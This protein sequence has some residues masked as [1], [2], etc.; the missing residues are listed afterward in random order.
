MKNF[1]TYTFSVLLTLAILNSACGP[2]NNSGCNNLNVIQNT[3]T[4]DIFVNSGG[5][6]PSADFEGNNDSGIYSFEW[7]NPK[8]RASLDFDITTTV[9][10]S[11]NIVLRDHEGIVVLNKTRPSGGEDSFSGVSDKGMRGTWTVE[12]TLMNVN[13]DGSWSM[14]PGD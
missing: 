8:G 13:G 2:D 6:D 5:Q 3:Y 1:K 11:V 4:G 10:G 7:C 14:H 9:G 12:V